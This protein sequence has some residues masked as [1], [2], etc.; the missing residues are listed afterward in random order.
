MVDAGFDRRLINFWRIIYL[1]FID[2]LFCALYQL[3]NIVLMP[4]DNDKTHQGCSPRQFDRLRKVPEYK[5]R[6]E[7]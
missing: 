3:F 2:S 4:P 6:Q 7:N 1:V 5:G